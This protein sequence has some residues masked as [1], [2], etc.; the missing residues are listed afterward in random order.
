MTTSTRCPRT[1]LGAVASIILAAT[2]AC[3]PD[4]GPAPGVVPDAVAA[5]VAAPQIQSA[6]LT[7][8][9][10]VAGSSPITRFEVSTNVGSAQTL[11]EDAVVRSLD[12]NA[13]YSFRVR[14]CNAT[15][16]G[17][18]SPKSNS[19]RPLPPVSSPDIVDD[20]TA[21]VGDRAATLSF[22]DPADGGSAITSVEVSVN[23]G[24][25]GPLAANRVVTGLTN[26]SAYTFR[27]RACNAVGCADWSTA[28]NS[29][30]PRGVPGAPSL[31]AGVSGTTINW[32]WN[33]PGGNGS[34][35]TGFVVRLDGNVVQGGLATSFGRGFGYAETHTLEVAAVNAAGTGPF[36]G[37]SARTV[38]P[39]PPPRTVGAA[40][41]PG[42]YK[43]GSCTSS[44]CAYLDVTIRNF[45]A[46]SPV[47]IQCW[48]S[49]GGASAF[50]SYNV[51]TDGAGN[52]FGRNC[53]Y[54]Y[55]GT[56]AWAVAGGVES[57]RV[58]W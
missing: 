5:V 9:A 16:C 25:A 38:D 54:G 10:P 36:S 35:V 8:V 13:T 58:T 22:T 50:Y 33:V 2:A 21:T 1:L 42:V 40:K 34:P 4:P 41:G 23:E 47:N 19:V 55:P 11:A 56:Q 44:A 53:W 30:T 37:A 57:N 27:V 32:S 6:K 3:V 28:T 39:P 29:V 45:P 31:G 17:L 26:G 48:G 7:F 51:T 49:F 12:E 20:L 15:G 52:A 14:A 43:P 18:W 24:A 46:N